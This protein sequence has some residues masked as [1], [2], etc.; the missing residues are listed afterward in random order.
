MNEEIEK[1]DNGD[2]VKLIVA[3]NEDFAFKFA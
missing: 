3:V 1:S 2:L